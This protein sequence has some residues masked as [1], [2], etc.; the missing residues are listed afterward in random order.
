MQL[1]E[2]LETLIRLAGTGE[3]AADIGTDHALV[4]L[5]LVR[6]GAFSRMIAGDVRKGPLAAAKANVEAAGLSDR[7]ALRLGDGLKVLEPGEAEVILI[8]GMGGALMR[9]ILAEGEEA[10]K[11]ARRLVLSPQSEIPEFRSFL[12]KNG[13]GITD[14]E[15][16]FEDGK[17][18]FL[19]TAEPGEQKPWK[20]AERLYGKHLLE[21]GGGTLKAYLEHRTAVLR[22]ILRNLEKTNA[23]RAQRKRRETEEE[24]ALAEEALKRLPA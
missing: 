2:R 11:A 19:M 10:A 23:P 5:E 14:E 16:V 3:R 1:S 7:I 22:E 21:K 20:K 13:Y 4:P 15:I 8:S 12:Q 9:R 17:Y 18:Y 6:R 24:L